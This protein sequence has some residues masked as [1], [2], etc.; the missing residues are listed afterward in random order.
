MHFE[1][2]VIR[3]DHAQIGRRGKIIPAGLEVRMDKLC[4][5]ELIHPV[6]FGIQLNVKKSALLSKKIHTL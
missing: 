1:I 5:F 2:N 6:E 3:C 4:S